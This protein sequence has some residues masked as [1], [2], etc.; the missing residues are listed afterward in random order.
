MKQIFK[1]GF[2]LLLI[3]SIAAFALGFTNE[4]TKDRIAEQRFLAN[5]QAKKD[6]LPVAASFVDITGEDLDAIVSQFEPITEAYI[7]LDAS[8]TPIGYVFKS[9]PNGF[10]GAVEVVTGVTIDKVVTGL[11]VGSHNETPGLGAKAKDAAFYE[12]FS[13]KSS[14]SQI[15]VSKTAASGNDIQAITGATIS[16]VAISKGANASIDAFN[17]ILENGGVGN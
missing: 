7:G 11:R 8:G 14:A 17:W 12:Q 2:I 13:G 5:E 4:V 16:S 10:S 1:I 6:V 9:T 15:G 3:S